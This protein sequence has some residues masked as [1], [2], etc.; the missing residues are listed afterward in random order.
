MIEFVLAFGLIWT[1]LVRRLSALVLTAMF[2]SAIF[3]FGKIDAIGHSM[4]IAIL[5]AVI[6][7]DSKAPVRRPIPVPI[8]YALALGATVTAYYGL[9]AVVFGAG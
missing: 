1:P 9:H 7:D 5:I 4:I 3:E 8:F 2:I 6:A